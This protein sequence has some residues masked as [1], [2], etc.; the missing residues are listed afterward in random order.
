MKQPEDRELWFQWLYHGKNKL[1][2]SYVERR[3]IAYREWVGLLISSTLVLLVYGTPLLVY[4]YYE[5]MEKNKIEVEQ[6][7]VVSYSQLMQ[8]PPIE[9]I[10]QPQQLIEK[11]TEVSTLKFVKPEVKK[12][13]EV[14]E[15]VYMPTQEEF[16]QANPGTETVQG[17]DSVVIE[18]VNVKVQEEPQDVLF[19]VVE[20][21]P[22]FPGGKEALMR[23]LASSLKYPQLA[24]ELNIQGVVIVQFTVDFTGRIRDVEVARGIGGG[25]DEEAV[26][27]I[28]NMPA[29]TPGRQNNRPVNV[30]YALPI[31]F[32]IQDY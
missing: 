8:P 14:A 24:R 5:R 4:R 2:G 31:R 6:F 15:E 27:V 25:C 22:E 12:D 18:Q 26:R 16:Q 29:W 19:A 3:K 7:T 10:N 28:Q 30:R 32:A 13:E 9:M 21:K 1:Y 17:I 23:Y 20:V 11:T